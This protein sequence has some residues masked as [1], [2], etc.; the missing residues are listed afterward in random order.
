[1]ADN[2]NIYAPWTASASVAGAVGASVSQAG[3]TGE[4]LV[5]TDFSATGD[6]TTLCTI[7]SPAGTIL[8]R[9]R[10]PSSGAYVIHL[11]PGVLVAAT[12]TAVVGRLAAATASSEVSI[13]GFKVKG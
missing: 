5:V 11:E 10:N 3:A 13:G 1:M 7:E 9:G 2:Y 4:K 6:L 8:W 12:N